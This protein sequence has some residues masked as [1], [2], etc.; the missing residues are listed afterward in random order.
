MKTCPACR[1]KIDARAIRCP[2]CQTQFS[3]ADMNAGRSESRRRF[4]LNLGAVLMVLYAIGYYL[5]SPENIKRR[6]EAEAR[7]EFR[8]Q[9]GQP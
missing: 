9:S 8:A 5:L 2:Y 3:L 7:R 1:K 6:A 4:W